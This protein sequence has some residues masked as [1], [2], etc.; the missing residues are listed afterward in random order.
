MDFI[1]SVLNIIIPPISIIFLFFFFLPPYLFFKSLFCTIRPIFSEV[2]SGKVVL[3]TGASSGIGERMAYVYARKEARLA[4]V[5]RRENRLQSVA[6]I[7][8][9]LGCKDVITIRADVSKVEDCERFVN[10]TINYYGRLDYL[11]NNAGVAPACMFEESPDITKFSQAM[12]INFWGSV[13]STYFAIPYLKR[14]GGRIVAISSAASWLP[15]P[16]LGLYSASKAAVTSFFETLRV[17]IGRDV[18]ITIVTPGLTES[19]MTQGKF[20]TERGTLELDQELR[21]YELS[22]PKAYLIVGQVIMS[23]TPVMPAEET[24]KA[25]IEGACQ[26]AYY[27]TIPAWMKPTY[28]WHAFLPEVLEWCNCLLLLLGPGSTDRETA[29]RKIVEALA[30]VRHYLRPGTVDS[31]E[32]GDEYRDY[33]YS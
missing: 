29:S 9:L 18:G 22:S 13:Y 26:G 30:T 33:P 2:V 8:T 31:P 15:V 20:L 1:N 32:L 4:L 16:R 11:V 5:A 14:T 21:D 19:E 7:A 10:E 24:A 17:E 12:D 6:S 28:L 25:I 27:L 3:I 23:L